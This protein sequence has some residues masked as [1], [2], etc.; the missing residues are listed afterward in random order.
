MNNHKILIP[1][2]AA[3]LVLFPACTR[4]SQKSHA[5]WEYPIEFGY[6]REMVH[7]FLSH[8]SRKTETLEEY[9]M[10]GVTVWFDSKDRLIK[11]NFQGEAAAAIYSSPDSMISANWIPSD[12]P[13]YSGL[14]AHSN[15]NEFMRVLG[16]PIRE[17]AAPAPYKRD[18]PFEDMLPDSTV[19]LPS[20]KEVRQI[21]KKD[22]YVIDVLFLSS[23]R[24]EGGKTFSK[25]ALLWCE[26]SRGL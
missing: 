24:N 14:T 12:K 10:S 23:D 15:E 19:I 20:P 17:Y 26:I 4:I 11:I 3:L 18:V 8:A 22:G 16:S 25:G 1:M 7:Q 21:F 9:P 5:S 2:I 6:S 13:F